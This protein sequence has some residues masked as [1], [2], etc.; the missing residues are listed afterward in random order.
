VYSFAAIEQF[1]RSA[2]GALSIVLIGLLPVLL[3]HE[4]VAG[5]R[6]GEHRQMPRW[7][8]AGVERL[9]GLR[10]PLKRIPLIRPR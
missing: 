7:L 3:L 6:S 8:L 5:G 9:R 4:A 10:K 2:L 1:E